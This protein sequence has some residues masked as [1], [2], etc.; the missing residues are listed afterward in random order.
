MCLPSCPLSILGEGLGVRTRSTGRMPVATGT[1][2]GGPRVRAMHPRRCHR[3]PFSAFWEGSGGPF[4]LS[5]K[6]FPGFFPAFPSSPG[7]SSFA[8]AIQGV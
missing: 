7:F 6:G 8:P 1:G 3:Q 5:K 4:F 2:K